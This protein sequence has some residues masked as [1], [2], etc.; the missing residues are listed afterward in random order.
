MKQDLT[1]IAV[2][3]DRS[4]S[5]KGLKTDMEVG[6]EK[7]LRDQA[8]EPGECRLTLAQFDTVYEVLADYI[9]V[10]DAPSFVLTPRNGTALLDAIGKTVT[11]VGEKLASLPEEERPAKVFVVI[12][13]DGLENSSVEW[14]QDQVAAL[15]KQQTEQWQW[16]F[17]YLG[18]N[19]DSFAV[20]ASMNI[21]RAATM[22]FAATSAG[23]QSMYSSTSNAMRR[24][25]GAV[26]SGA[27]GQS[28]SYTQEER[29]EAKG[30]K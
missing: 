7:F 17:V 1:L 11:E 24:A 26:R 15:I 6:L 29:E 13:T 14:R 25:R 9:D 23:T 2:V 5:M 16:E 21:A 19:Q 28:L 12:I 18:A 8:A 22:D 30:S 27:S 4:G 20:G 10:K 3:L